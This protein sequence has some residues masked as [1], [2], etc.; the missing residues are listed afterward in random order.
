MHT[1]V[2]GYSHR[3]DNAIDDYAI[4][5]SDVQWNSFSANERL[6]QVPTQDSHCIDARCTTI[7]WQGVLPRISDGNIFVS[8][9]RILLLV[10][11]N[12]TI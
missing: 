3:S 8:R 6:V 4:R 5:H 11:G 10:V 12:R 2:M 9:K 1:R 7:Q